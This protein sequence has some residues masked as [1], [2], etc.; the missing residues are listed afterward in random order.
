MRGPVALS[1]KLTLEEVVRQSDNAGGFVESWVAVGQL[2]AEMQAGTG[3]ERSSGTV[4]LAS[5]PL[6]VVVRAAPVGS[7]SRPKPG[8]RF[9]EGSRIYRIEAVAEADRPGHYLQCFAREEVAT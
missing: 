3:R 2:W 8:Q 9:V 4:S 7:A 1:R 6:R 5:V